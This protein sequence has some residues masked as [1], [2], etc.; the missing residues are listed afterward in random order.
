MPPKK[1]VEEDTSCARFG[2]AL[3][4]A[5]G[6][7]RHHLSPDALRSRRVRNNLKMG[8]VG[9]PNVGKSS[10]FNLLCEMSAAAENCTCLHASARLR[11]AR[12]RSSPLNRVWLRYRPLLHHRAQREPLR[13]ARR[14][15]RVAM[16]CA[17]TM[18]SPPYYSSRLAPR[19]QTCGSR[20]VN[21][22]PTCT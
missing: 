14:A 18:Y 4:V 8:V 5:A 3:R 6:G 20:P 10:L 13:S 12:S 7:G 2:C 21:T 9:L 11:A 19:N 15:L 16:Q 1:V 17:L 22:Q